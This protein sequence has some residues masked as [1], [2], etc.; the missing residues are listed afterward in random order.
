[1]NGAGLVLIFRHRRVLDGDLSSDYFL[2]YCLADFFQIGNRQVRLFTILAENP[3][4]PV[5]EALGDDFRLGS[6]DLKFRNIVVDVW[7]CAI[8]QPKVRGFM[9]S[10]LA[11]FEPSRGKR[12]CAEKL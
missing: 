9:Q 1:M 12:R 7:L 6:C 3:T 4:I 5:I 10:P 11:N 8:D 2:S